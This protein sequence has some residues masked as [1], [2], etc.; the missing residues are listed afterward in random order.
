V[1]NRKSQETAVELDGLPPSLEALYTT[2]TVEKAY[3]GFAG[4]VKQSIDEAGVRPQAPAYQDVSLAVQDALHPPDKI[5]PHD[6]GPSYDELK[7]NLE[8]AVKR[9]GLL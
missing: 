1:S 3:P 9:K 2:K 8:D 7:G 6:P 5:D 4:L